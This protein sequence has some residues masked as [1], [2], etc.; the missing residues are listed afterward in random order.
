MKRVLLTLAVVLTAA[1]G[2]C[3]TAIGHWRDCLDHSMVH[4]VV[5]AGERVYGAVRGGVFYYDL[6][7]LTLTRLNKTTGLSD[8]GV[9]TIAYDATMQCLAVAYNN[10]NLKAQIGRAHV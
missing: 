2:C 1:V 6:G 3:Q 10:S 4:C 8:A 7:D 9:A 5:P